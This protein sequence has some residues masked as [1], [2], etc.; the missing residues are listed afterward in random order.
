MRSNST[1]QRA[2]MATMH[3]EDRGRRSSQNPLIF[4]HFVG[5][6]R[7]LRISS[8]ASIDQSTRSCRGDPTCPG[9]T[10]AGCG[11]GWMGGPTTLLL[12]LPSLTSGRR[13]CPSPL[14]VQRSMPVDGNEPIDPI[15]TSCPGT[16]RTTQRSSPPPPQPRPTH[17]GRRERR[18][19]RLR[20][21]FPCTT[22]LSLRWVQGEEM[23]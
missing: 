18:P 14:R 11:T 19:I 3:A 22:Y 10:V 7:W 16:G 23:P 2:E 8:S 20:Q 6:V 12:S 17:R 4:R 1:R 15:G 9:S 21:P 5:K 13:S